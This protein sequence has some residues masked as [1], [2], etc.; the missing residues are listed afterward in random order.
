M[1]PTRV[2]PPIY[3]LR[4]LREWVT[5]DDAFD[6]HEMLAVEDALNAKREAERARG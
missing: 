1:R 6:A 3:T 2:T 4:D 5:I